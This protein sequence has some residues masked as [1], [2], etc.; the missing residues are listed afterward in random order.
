[1]TWLSLLAFCN[2][3][4]IIWHC[5]SPFE[6]QWWYK[7]KRA[8][9]ISIYRILLYHRCNQLR[10][11]WYFRK[12]V[13]AHFVIY[14]TIAAIYDWQMSNQPQMR[15]VNVVP[16]LMKQ[17][18]L[19]YFMC[20]LYYLISDVGNGIRIEIVCEKNDNVFQ[21]NFCKKCMSLNKIWLGSD[22]FECN[23]S[24]IYLDWILNYVHN[25]LAWIT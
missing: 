12:F 13:H 7:A 15:L 18:A 10:N 23:Y 1:M 16:F 3:N 2:T 8:T 17:K 20:L 19:I 24:I 5:A 6:F 21:W 9:I 25:I 4:Q 11:I 22:L 14:Q